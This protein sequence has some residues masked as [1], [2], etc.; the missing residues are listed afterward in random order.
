LQKQYG[1]VFL[2]HSVDGPQ[3]QTVDQFA[4]TREDVCDTD[5]QTH[6]LQ[7]PKNFFIWS[8]RDLDPMTL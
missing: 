1:A 8:R 4:F 7:I 2:S 6:E 5:V 3:Q